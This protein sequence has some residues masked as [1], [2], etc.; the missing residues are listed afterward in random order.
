MGAEARASRAQNIPGKSPQAGL[1]QEP[2][3][4]PVSLVFWYFQE[5]GWVRELESQVSGKGC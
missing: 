3:Q 4:T 2:W 5:L 1:S